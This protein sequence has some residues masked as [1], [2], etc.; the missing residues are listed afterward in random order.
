MESRAE[1]A[2]DLCWAPV[3]PQRCSQA[4]SDAGDSNRAVE[5][6]RLSSADPRDLRSSK[7]KGLEIQSYASGAEDRVGVRSEGGG[8]SSF[9]LPCSQWGNVPPVT[10]KVSLGL[11]IAGQAVGLAKLRDEVTSREDVPGCCFRRMR[12]EDVRPA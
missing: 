4:A 9:L 2:C 8:S 6:S 11:L 1:C 3:P 7:I 10:S 12:Q 5:R